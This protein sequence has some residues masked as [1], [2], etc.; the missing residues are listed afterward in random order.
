MSSLSSSVVKNSLAWQ[1]AIVQ[2]WLVDQRVPYQ[3][4]TI[5]ETVYP[6]TATQQEVTIWRSFIKYQ[7]PDGT[8]KVLHGY[9][10][11]TG[12][13]LSS[14]AELVRKVFCDNP[15]LYNIVFAYRQDVLLRKQKLNFLDTDL[16]MFGEYAPI[17]VSI[18][19]D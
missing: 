5:K 18:E 15:G 11:Y 6:K 4:G 2:Q 7:Q 16:A 14:L 12:G 17:D 9:T 10:A 3:Y 13:A 19:F 1:V 8:Y